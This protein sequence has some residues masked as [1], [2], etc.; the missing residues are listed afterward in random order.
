LSC[1]A[2]LASDQNAS[3]QASVCQPVSISL[4]DGFHARSIPH[5]P[6]DHTVQLR[7]FL[8]PAEVEDLERQRHTGGGDDFM[9][10]CGVDLIVG[11]L[12]TLNSFGPGQTP[13]PTPWEINFGLFSQVMPF[14]TTRVY[15]VRVQMEQSK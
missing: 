15:P 1:A 5:G 10:N 9:L 3:P 12:K 11:G 14:W 2:R 13:E 6:N 7:F 8:R 4:I